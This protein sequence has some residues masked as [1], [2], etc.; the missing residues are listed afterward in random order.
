M[1]LGRGAPSLTERCDELD[2]QCRRTCQIVRVWSTDRILSSLNGA[3]A[4]RRIFGCKGMD[5][6]GLHQPDGALVSMVHHSLNRVSGD[7]EEGRRQVSREL[8]KEVEAHNMVPA[9]LE[10]N[11]I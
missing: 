5:W 8:E 10:R 7:R 2:E 6:D 4:W 9:V 1:E 11:E 3:A